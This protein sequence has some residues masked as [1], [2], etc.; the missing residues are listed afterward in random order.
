MLR[1]ELVKGYR[2]PLS[3]DAFQELVPMPPDAEVN[4]IE[5][6][7]ASQHLYKVVLPNF[8]KVR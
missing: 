2:I 4:N 1:P 7:A 3:S 6:A 5:V 8:V